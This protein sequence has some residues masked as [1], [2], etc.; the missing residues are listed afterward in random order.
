MNG[1]AP[2]CSETFADLRGRPYFLCFDRVEDCA[3][4]ERS[5]A[6]EVCYFGCGTMTA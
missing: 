2:L 6:K 4:P 3:K 5:T 1:R